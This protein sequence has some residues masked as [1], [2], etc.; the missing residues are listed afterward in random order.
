MA[1]E[2]YISNAV[3]ETFD[4]DSIEL[5]MEIYKLK[6]LA[7]VFR[8]MKR[9]AELCIDSEKVTKLA[10]WHEITSIG[11]IVFK[12]MYK[13]AWGSYYLLTYSIYEVKE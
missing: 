2:L 1:Y 10:E 13:S 12:E 3:K 9:Y 8:R 5:P 6:T 4:A 7:D 11:A